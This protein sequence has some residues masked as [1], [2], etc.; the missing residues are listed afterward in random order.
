MGSE[1]KSTCVNIFILN[2]QASY[3]KQVQ[4]LYKCMTTLARTN[5]HITGSCT[6]SNQW[7]N[8]TQT[9]TQTKE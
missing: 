4:V 6:A 1:A 7:F 8:I 9:T 3:Q 2:L 5:Q